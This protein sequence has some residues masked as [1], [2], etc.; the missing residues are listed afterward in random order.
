MLE[1]V[2]GRLRCSPRPEVGIGGR[3]R[4]SGIAQLLCDEL[5]LHGAEHAHRN[6]GSRSNRFSTERRDELD[7]DR[8]GLR[9]KSR[10][11]GGRM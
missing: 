9:R 6:V 4:R 11:S 8:P 3:R 10:N 1:Q 2:V 5:E 7:S